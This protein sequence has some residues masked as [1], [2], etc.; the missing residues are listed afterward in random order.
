MDIPNNLKSLATGFDSLIGVNIIELTP[1]GGYAQFNISDIFL[2]PQGIV[3]GGVYCSIIESLASASGY[4]WLLENGGKA[5]F[6]VNNNTDFLIS[7][8]S[9][10]LT[11]TSIPIQRGLVQQL[12]LVTVSDEYK[13]LVSIGR[14]RMQNICD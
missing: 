11:A 9:G 13:N 4:L 2:Q 7:V 14:V 6:G 3:H 1:D 12:W 8:N 10:V 5:L